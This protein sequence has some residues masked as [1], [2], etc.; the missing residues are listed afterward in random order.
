MELHRCCWTVLHIHVQALVVHGPPLTLGVPSARV[1]IFYFP[2]HL[3]VDALAADRVVLGVAT[4][5]AQSS[6]DRGGLAS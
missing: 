3:G 1:L 4:H 2:A 6:G 5:F